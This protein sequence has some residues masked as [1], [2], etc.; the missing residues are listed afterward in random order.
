[1]Y[2][3]KRFTPQQVL[4][5]WLSE[6]PASRRFR[7]DPELDAEIARRFG[8]LLLQAERGLPAHWHED[9][10]GLLALIIV[11]DQ[12]T[13][14][15]RRG[16]AAAFAGD[17]RALQLTWTALCRGYLAACSEDEAQFM[18]M[19]LMHSERLALQQASLPL[20]AAY[21]GETAHRYAIAHHDIIARFGR[22]PHRNAVLGRE[23]S[24]EELAFL[25]EP[26][27]SF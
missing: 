7:A 23:S 1:M 6:T 17:E 14:N 5:F 25:Q 22:F 13:R 8:A 24:A 4:G 12:F 11:F 9:R 18:L 2:T 20:F 26:G 19:P 3:G 27:S 16:T 15:I 10:H 21:A